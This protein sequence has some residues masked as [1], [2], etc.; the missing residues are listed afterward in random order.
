M[1]LSSLLPAV[2]SLGIVLFPAAE[3]GGGQL[4]EG[5]F[6]LGKILGEATEP[7]HLNW[8]VI[9]AFDEGL[10]TAFSSRPGGVGTVVFRPLQIFRTIDRTSPD[11]YLIAADGRRLDT[12]T[13]ELVRR[14]S[15]G[16]SSQALK[17][18]LTGVRISA[19][20]SDG[21]SG[22]SPTERISLA[23]EGLT[24]NSVTITGSVRPQS[25][26]LLRASA[27]DPGEANAGFAG[28]DGVDVQPNAEPMTAGE[29][30]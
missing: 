22:Q 28:A 26:V 25:I 16:V 1:R 17:I 4:W 20:A 9:T 10:D 8:S 7:N 21:S 12:G 3:A 23:F 11:F 24:I 18:D 27:P 6:R 14:S 13:L 2:V 5:Y 19:I 30:P 15:Q 29:S